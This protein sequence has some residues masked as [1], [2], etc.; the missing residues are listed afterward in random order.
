VTAARRPATHIRRLT[1]RDLFKAAPI[2]CAGVAAAGVGLAARHPGS[3]EKVRGS[4]RFCLLH[5]GL[6]ATVQGGRLLRVDGD[7]D[8]PTKGFLCLHG[9]ALPEVVHSRERVRMPLLRRGESLEEVSWSEALGLISERLHQVRG[10]FGPEALV[11]QTGWPLVRHPLTEMIQRL[12]QAWGTPNVVSVGSLCETAGRMGQALTVGSKYKHDLHRART[13]VLWGANPTHSTPLFS[14]VV[15]AKASDGN[16]VVVDPVRTELAVTAT[17]HLAVRP[18]TDGALALGMMQVI[19]SEHRHDPRFIASSTVGFEAL[20]RL[21]AEYP[22][23]RT[24]LLTGVSAEQ[25]IRVARML[26]RDTPTAIWGGLGVEHHENGVQNVRALACLEALCQRADAHDIRQILTPAGMAGPDEPLPALPRLSTPEPVP[27]PVQAR[28]LGADSHPLFHAFNREAQGNLLARAILHDTPYPVRALI[29]LG[30]NALVTTPGTQ[31]LRLAAGKL[32][33]LVTIDPFLSESARLSDVVLPA[34]TFAE[35]PVP[36]EG[37]APP[38]HGL[39]PPQHGA[40]PDWKIVFELGRALGLGAYFPWRNFAEAMQAPRRPYMVDRPTQPRPEPGSRPARYGTASGKI[41]LASVL[42]ERHGY[43]AVPRWR[44]PTVGVSPDYPLLLVTGA[45]TRAYINSQFRQ[46]A[47]VRLRMP[48]PEVL[49]HPD[50]ARS[51]GV[52][53]GE[54]VAI[55]APLGRVEM[56]I[57]VTTEVRPDVA[58]APA[59]WESANVNVLHDAERLDPISGFPAFR[60]GVCRI[61]RAPPAPAARP[62]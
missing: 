5:C 45:R 27:P 54:R 44:P 12:G 51:A 46:V 60:S 37:S 49:L 7:L 17:E 10:E 36:G 16:L 34:T 55:V 15:A 32:R 42:L 25:I 1:R 38:S 50:A 26:A 48:E 14:H 4:C 56:K 22:P 47:K 28:P 24:A 6:V 30:S 61:E 8:S 18:G 19:L 13:V 53:D 31:A 62:G 59:G 35:A 11:L 39:V 52:R 20:A 41:E 33:L 58:V 23:E 3:T 21:A 40:W 43:D 2:A 57:R 29:L 9:H